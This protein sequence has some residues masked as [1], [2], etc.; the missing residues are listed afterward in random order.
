MR[1]PNKKHY[2]YAWLV[3]ELAHDFRL[4]DFWEFPI[5][6]AP[7]KHSL[8]LFRKE[9]LK[10][11]MDNIMEAGVAGTLFR[12]RGW[13]GEIFEWDA[14]RNQ[15][16]IPNCSETSIKARF[17][18]EN[19]QQHQA[20][21]DLSQKNKDY[22]QFQTVYALEN[23]TLQEIS[24][25]TVHALLHLAWVPKTETT[26]T[27]QMAVYVKVRGRLGQLYMEAIKPFRWWIVYPTIMKLVGQAWESYVASNELPSPTNKGSMIPQS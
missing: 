26:Y 19:L 3:H 2:D 5:E 24:N 27:V 22:T 8:Y 6:A 13:L 25:K 23:E 20:S 7:Q 14:T 11:V 18:Q 15:E 9:A 12:F 16:P 1:I 21:L 17:H 10:P 4:E